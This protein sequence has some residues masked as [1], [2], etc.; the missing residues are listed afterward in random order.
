MK[1][2]NNVLREKAKKVVGEDL[3]KTPLFVGGDRI[4]P[5]TL[6]SSVERILE[7]S[8]GLQDFENLR[9][10]KYDTEADEQISFEDD[11]FD[12]E[13]DNL[14]MGVHSFYEDLRRT[15]LELQ[16][17]KKQ[18]QESH[19]NETPA[20]DTEVSTLEAEKSSA[21]DSIAKKGTTGAD[22]P[23]ESRVSES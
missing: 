1:E 5:Q 4:L 11:G 8:S 10:F 19:S 23:A 20:K 15:E 22:A 3:D 9:G 6:A 12:G 2:F 17:A 7:V 18:A 21:P 13:P 14:T 16:S